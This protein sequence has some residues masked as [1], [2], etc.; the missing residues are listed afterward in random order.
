VRSS[1]RGVADWLGDWGADDRVRTECRRM[2]SPAAQQRRAERL[3]D[4][5][6]PGPLTL[7]LLTAPVKEP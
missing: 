6:V 2:R 7:A 3:V 5:G 4:E 1:A